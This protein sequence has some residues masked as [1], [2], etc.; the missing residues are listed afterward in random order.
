MLAQGISDAF[1]D[2][3]ALAVAIDAGLGGRQPLD[4]ALSE[5]EQRR[6]VAGL[7]GYAATVRACALPPAPPELLRLR[8]ALRGNQ[9]DTDQYYMASSSGR[10]RTRTST[11][12]TTSPGLS[13]RLLPPAPVRLRAEKSQFDLG[14]HAPRRRP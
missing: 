10:L 9:L 3:E 11:R 8:A 4:A 13:P 2:A 7:P 14:T 6:D 1:C 12:R 5:F